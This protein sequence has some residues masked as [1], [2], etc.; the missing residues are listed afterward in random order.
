MDS[1]IFFVDSREL[2]MPV[3]NE[4]DVRSVLQ[5]FHIRLRHVVDDAWQEW[6]DS[7]GKAKW[8]FLPRVRAV[9]VFDFIARRAL[10]EFATDPNIHVI[11][12]KQTVQ[13]LFKGEV[14]VRF[15]KGNAKGVGSN[16]LTQSVLDFI[17]PQ[18]E[19]PGL[20]P[21]IMKV[22]VCY[23]LNELGINLSEVAVVARNERARLWAYPLD[24]AEPAADIIPIPTAPIA[25]DTNPPIVVP[26][27]PRAD[28]A[29]DDKQ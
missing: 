19:I 12:K 4:A 21:E 23:S 13:F 26:R 28:E 22:E 29:S 3:P 17:D 27:Q 8:V 7:P 10:E 6:L 14:L 9:M 16:I 5:D 18:R 11:V 25:P 1:G 2:P 15:K 24:R 20:V